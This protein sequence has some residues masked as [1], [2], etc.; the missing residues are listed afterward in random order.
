M[1]MEVIESYLHGLKMILIFVMCK[2]LVWLSLWDLF[3][4][5]FQRAINQSH[6]VL[7]EWCNLTWC[8]IINKQKKLTYT[9]H[10]YNVLG[11]RKS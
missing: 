1:E 7:F 9:P 10:M 11:N 4:I 8:Y 5:L 6:L 2:L 3:Q